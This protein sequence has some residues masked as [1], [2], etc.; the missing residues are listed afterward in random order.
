MHIYTS[1]D[2]CLCGKGLWVL[3]GR[4]ERQERQGRQRRQ[5]RKGNKL[6][7]DAEEDVV[8]DVR[9]LLCN[10]DGLEVVK[11]LLTR[12]LRLN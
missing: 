11:V 9:H 8:V 12:E 10:V 7:T 3:A 1:Y 5:G 2:V 6:D 4:Q